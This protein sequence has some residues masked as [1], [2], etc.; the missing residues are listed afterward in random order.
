MGTVAVK[1]VDEKLFRRVKALASLE[2]KTMGEEVNEALATWLGQRTTDPELLS[3]WEDLENEA[4]VNNGLLERLRPELL[5]THPGEFAV[6]TS[7]KLVGV[8]KREEDACRE[9]SKGGRQA[10]VAHLVA[11]TERVVELGWS[12]LDG[13]MT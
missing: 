5:S 4:V 2:G 8:F 12:N 7:G 10:V 9:A 3:R 6:V 13:P 1:N 11:R